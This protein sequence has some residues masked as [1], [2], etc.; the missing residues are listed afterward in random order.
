MRIALVTPARAGTRTG[1]RH[2]ALRWA[3]M[4]R[5]AGHRVSVATEWSGEDAD[6]ML[7]LHARRSHDSIK[8]FS[9][10]HPER[11]LVLAL[12]GTDVYRD[13][14]TSNAARESLGL[15]HRFIVLQPL[16]IEELPAPLRGKA[17]VVYQSCATRLRHSP[18]KRG[19]RVCVIG[20]LREEKDP[21]LALA[22]L[23]HL[24]SDAEIEVVQIGEALDARFAK[25]ARTAMKREPRYRWLGGVPHARALRWLASSHAMVISSRMEGGANVVSEALRIGVPVLASR[26]PGNVGLLGRG[27]AGY[28]PVGDARALAGLM[29]RAA[30]DPGF[31]RRLRRACLRL[32]SI[33]VPANEVRMLRQALGI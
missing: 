10:A 22:A 23:G 28:F 3:A 30:C 29:R 24:P 33:V 8:A 11:P 26:I 7:A 17:R 31:Y 19:F 20:H 5:K 2:T 4:L 9:D 1:N 6:L 16:A 18:V 32:R 13:I 15:A 14:R 21:L 12:T 25:E 27:Y